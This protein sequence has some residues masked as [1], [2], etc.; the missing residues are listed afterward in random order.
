MEENNIALTKRLLFS[1][2]DATTFNSAR[3]LLLFETLHIIDNEKS[4][5]DMERLCYYDFFAANPFLIIKDDNPER[6]LLEIEGF[7]PNKLEYLTTVQRYETKRLQVKH[8]I[9]VLVSKGLITVENYDKK[10]V[11]S[12]THLGLTI[13]NRIN[14]MYAIAYRKSVSFVI[15]KLK[16]YTD[17]QL[18]EQASIWLR[19]KTFQVDL[20]RVI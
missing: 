8:Y 4:Q 7:D 20:V 6:L 12:I 9:A 19:A 15:R 11:Y 1:V 2:E 18:N 5:I 17:P 13:S 10:I 16:R 3:L 14:S